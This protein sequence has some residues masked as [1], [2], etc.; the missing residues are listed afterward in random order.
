[1][2]VMNKI[3]EASIESNNALPECNCHLGKAK[4][5]G[6]THETQMQQSPKKA[7]LYQGETFVLNDRSFFI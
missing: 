3:S 1:M 2:P 5:Y 7:D 4:D 6:S